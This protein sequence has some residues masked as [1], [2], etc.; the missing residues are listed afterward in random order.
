MKNTM[1]KM[2]SID[3]NIDEWKMLFQLI[4]LIMFNFYQLYILKN[5][6]LH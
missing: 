2:Q 3:F 1:K 5:M 6:K 4:N